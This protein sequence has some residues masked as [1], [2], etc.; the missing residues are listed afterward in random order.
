MYRHTCTQSEQS[1]QLDMVGKPFSSEVP[2]TPIP[3]GESRSS[4][5]NNG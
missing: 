3:T 5:R 1:I 2:L 4:E